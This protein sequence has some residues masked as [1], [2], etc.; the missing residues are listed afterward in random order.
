M[1]AVSRASSGKRIGNP[2]SRQS[3]RDDGGKPERKRPF[4][5]PNIQE[6]GGGT[7]PLPDH[8]HSV[9]KFTFGRELPVGFPVP[10]STQMTSCE[11]IPIAFGSPTY[12][13]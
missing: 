12:S 7:R 3:G 2:V 5:H 4:H 13:E 1:V 6:E 8:Y 10:T 11:Y 9:K